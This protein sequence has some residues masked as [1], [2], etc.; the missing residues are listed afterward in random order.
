MNKRDYAFLLIISCCLTA[1]FLNQKSQVEYQV[2]SFENVTG[3]HV[4]LFDLNSQLDEK[5]KQI[6]C[7]K[8]K[9]IKVTVTL[10]LHDSNKDAFISKAI[11]TNGIWEEPIIG[12]LLKL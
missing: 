9:E 6:F 11:K 10:C 5:E 8:S 12:R 3:S 7:Q 4:Q 2:L 1:L